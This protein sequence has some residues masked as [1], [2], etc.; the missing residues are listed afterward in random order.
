MLKLLSTAKENHLPMKMVKFDKRKHKKAK[1]MS[2]GLL[3]SI[4]TK[5]RL[6]E[7]LIRTDIEDPQYVGCSGEN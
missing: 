4:N 3:K 1:W 7:K 5:D 2:N 6:Y